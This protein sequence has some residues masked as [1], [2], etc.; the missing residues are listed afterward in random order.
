[1]TRRKVHSFIPIIHRA[2]SSI[3][4]FSALFFSQ[5]ILADENNSKPILIIGASY[6]NGVT[7]I[8]DNLNGPFG[9][10]ASEYG[11]YLSLGNALIRTD[12]LDGFVINEAEAGAT[13]FYRLHCGLTFC[14]TTGWQGMDVQFQKA[15]SRVTIRDLSGNILGYN[16]DY[17][18]VGLPNDCLHS[19]ATGLPQLN[20]SPCTYGELNGVVDRLRDIAQ[21][22]VSLGITPVFNTMPKYSDLDLPFFQAAFGLTWVI[23]EAGYNELRDLIQSRIQSEVPE[24]LFVDA[25][26]EFETLADGLHPNYDTTTKAAKRIAQAILYHQQHSI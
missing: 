22:A 12:Q 20:T 11:S 3:L 9:G 8:D 6:E 2:L 15:L 14:L 16:A 21:Q 23:D 5:V 13:T 1:M 17:L 18:I 25:W 7:P 10:F 24:A 4:L 26:A 19:G